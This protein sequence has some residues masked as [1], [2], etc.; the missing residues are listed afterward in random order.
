MTNILEYLEQTAERLPDKVCY[1]D[2]KTSMTFSEVHRAARGIGTCISRMG[3]Y[4]K[5][6]AVFMKKGPYEVT[7]FLGAAYAGCYY[8]PFDAEMP[9]FRIELIFRT[10]GDCAVICDGSALPLLEKV[11]REKDAVLCSEAA[12][13][14]PDDALLS[15]IRARHI[16]TDPLYVLFTSGS[17]GVPKGVVACHRS[18]INY[19]DRLSDVLNVSEDTVFGNQTPLYTDAC[20]KELFPTL[21]CGA[22]AVF[23]PKMLFSFPVRL[24]GFLNE[25]RINTI[26]WVA[27]ALSIVSSVGTFDTIKPEFLRTVGISSEVFPVKQYH[28]WQKVLPDAKFINLYGPTECTGVSCWYIV[29]REFRDDEVLPIGKPFQNT[30]AMLLSEDGKEVPQ[31]EIGEICLRGTCVTFGYYSNPE[32]TSAAFVQNP[33]NSVY[34]EIIYRTG[35]LGRLNERGELVFVSR[36]DF[37]IKHMGYRIELGEIE[38]AASTCDGVSLCCCLY[39]TQKKKIIL[40]VTGTVD[41]NELLKYLKSRL[42]RYMIPGEIMLLAAMPLTLN[43]KLDRKLLLSVIEGKADIAGINGQ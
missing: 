32:R 11:G 16:D 25:N 43:G 34:P 35:D 3:Y 36:K 14:V 6:V 9:L 1:T 38:A 39:D 31:G 42:P 4:R 5:P 22:T 8:V 2:G 15:G 27:S 40:F 37:Q 29:D 13:T 21:K 17:T 19:I 41:R 24:I 30:E 26:C 10:L 20:M 28:I 18:V 23:I 7:A 33:L 12:E